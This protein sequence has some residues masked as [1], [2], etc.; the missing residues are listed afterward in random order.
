MEP[1]VKEGGGERIAKS[2]FLLTWWFV[3]SIKKG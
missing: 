2:L 3:G 1:K